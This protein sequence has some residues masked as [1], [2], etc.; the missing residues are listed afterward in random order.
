MSAAVH[1]LSC[2]QTFLPYLAMVKNLKIRSCDFDFWPTTLKFSG[3]HAVVKIHGYAKISSSYVQRFIWVIVRTEKNNFDENNTVGRCRGQ[4]KVKKHPMV[5]GVYIAHMGRKTHEQIEPKF[6]LLV[7][8]CDAIAW[9]KFGDD[10]LRGLQSA[11]GQSS[12]FPIDF[13]GRPYNTLALLTRSGCEA[14]DG[15]AGRMAV[16]S[17][18][19]IVRM[20]R[21]RSG[22]TTQPTRPVA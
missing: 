14:V 22:Q 7:S 4:W 20:V 1:E 8:I 19:K 2:A 12:P 13:D 15:F 17:G 10:R 5:E 3:F 18:M 6:F 21:P 11:E 16:E 9:F